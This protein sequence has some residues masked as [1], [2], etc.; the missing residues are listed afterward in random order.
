ML[1]SIIFQHWNT[2]VIRMVAR[3][4]AILVE[5]A[6]VDIPA[7]VLAVSGMAKNHVIITMILY[8]NSQAIYAWIYTVWSRNFSACIL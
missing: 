8:F 1:P 3:L 4:I 7:S 6:D 2:T 5:V